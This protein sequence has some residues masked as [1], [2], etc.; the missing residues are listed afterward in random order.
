MQDLEEVDRVA[1]SASVIL[2]H[3]RVHIWAINVIIDDAGSGVLRGIGNVVLPLKQNEW[4]RLMLGQVAIL[5]DLTQIW[6]IFNP[7]H[8]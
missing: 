2:G 4:F 6:E 7:P 1:I 5:D 3:T 8:P